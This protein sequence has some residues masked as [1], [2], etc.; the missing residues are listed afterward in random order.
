MTRMHWPALRG[1]RRSCPSLLHWRRSARQ[2]L[3]L[4]HRD[5]R[6][7]AGTRP[8]RQHR[9]GRAGPV[10]LLPAAPRGE[11]LL[12]SFPL[13]ARR[14]AWLPVGLSWRS[15]NVPFSSLKCLEGV[16]SSAQ[17]EQYCW[18]ILGEKAPRTESII[19][20]SKVAGWCVGSTSAR[21]RQG[22]LVSWALLQ[23]GSGCR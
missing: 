10:G 13:R 15:Q 11:S 6:G 20:K 7:P 22:R 16:Q 2:R 14:V 8:V 17:S 18:T 9:P 3:C 12:G 1:S 5:E 4:T 23:R 21:S 19:I